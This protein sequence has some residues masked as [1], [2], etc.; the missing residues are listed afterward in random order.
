MTGRSVT[1]FGRT[2][3]R[4]RALP[5]VLGALSGELRALADLSESLQEP[6][7]ALIASV[8]TNAAADYAE[9]QSADMLTQALGD[10]SDFCATL[11]DAVAEEAPLDPAALARA[12]RLA[13]LAARLSGPAPAGAGVRPSHAGHCDFFGD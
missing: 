10:L 12:L 4:L 2:P 11:A 1:K 8:G 5:A 9:L 3:K 7:A 13:D 6:I